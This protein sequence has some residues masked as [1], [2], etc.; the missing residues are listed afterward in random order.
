M[1]KGAAGLRAR[2]RGVWA[3][4]VHPAERLHFSQPLSDAGDRPE[5]QGNYGNAALK[6]STAFFQFFLATKQRQPEVFMPLLYK[7][8]LSLSAGT[9]PTFLI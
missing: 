1:G 2:G 7:T 6:P 4:A 5:L 9:S 3:F 8:R